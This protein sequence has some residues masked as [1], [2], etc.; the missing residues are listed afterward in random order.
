M[1]KLAVDI[2]FNYAL[3]Q[4]RFVSMLSLLGACIDR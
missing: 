3:V 4:H 2:D 1:I